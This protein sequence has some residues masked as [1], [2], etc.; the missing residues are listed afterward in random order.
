M[1][2]ETVGVLHRNRLQRSA[3][4]LDQCLAGARPG[5]AQ[6]RLDLRKRFFYGVEVGRVWRQVEQLAEP[7]SSMSSL[8]LPPLCEERL[9]ITTT[10][11]GLSEG[12]KTRSR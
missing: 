12:A 3:H 5:F 2:E 6:Q 4:R 7:R 11:P 1:L 8:T 10:C 9:S